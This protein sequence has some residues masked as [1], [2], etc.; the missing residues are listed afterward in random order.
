[1]QRESGLTFGQALMAANSPVLIERSM[2]QGRPAEGVMSTGQVAGILSDLPT[3]E[4]LIVRMV[5][6]ARQRLNALSG[7]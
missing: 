4:E 6:E 1:M 3:C 5:T 7:G 2:I